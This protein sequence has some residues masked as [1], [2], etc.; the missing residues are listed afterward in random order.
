M[1]VAAQPRTAHDV[2]MA[3]L[4]TVV[5]MNGSLSRKTLDG[6]WVVYQPHP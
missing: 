1:Q 4:E 6:G 2:L 3:S 5:C